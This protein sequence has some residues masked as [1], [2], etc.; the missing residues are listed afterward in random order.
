ME[1]SWGR[2]EL[3][4]DGLIFVLQG[5]QLALHGEQFFSQCGVLEPQVIQFRKQ[6]PK[7]RRERQDLPKP[8]LQ[9]S[10]A[11]YEI[12]RNPCNRRVKMRHSRAYVAASTRTP[13]Q[14]DSDRCGGFFN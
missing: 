4:D 10:H 3:I 1:M 7:R 6:S 14:Q 9:G 8:C 5:L 2:P 11:D 13:V 12:T